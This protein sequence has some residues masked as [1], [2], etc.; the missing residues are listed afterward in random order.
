[1]SNPNI[2][3]VEDNY[4][5][6]SEIQNYL[7]NCS[8]NI[9][10]HAI[11]GMDAIEMTRSKNPDVVIM[12]IGL[13]GE[14]S[15]IEAAG[16]IQKNSETPII[17]LTE[18][19]S[20]Y[21]YREVKKNVKSEFVSKPFKSIHLLNALDNVFLR[22]W[23]YVPN[24][25][26]TLYAR[27]KQGNPHAFVCFQASDILFIRGHGSNSTVFTYE[28]TYAITSSLQQIEIRLSKIDYFVRVNRF[29]IVNASIVHLVEGKSN[30]KSFKVDRKDKQTEH[31]TISAKYQKQV[32]EKIFRL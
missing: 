13:E 10:G 17:F 6:A 25:N 27:L 11:S 18:E 5:H 29:E 24:L 4:F 22:Y 7:E 16:E 31:I 9:V 26:T 3:I 19:E 14:M 23:E 15:G 30:V 21:R 28:A 20:Q 12:D 2:L 32:L 1:M 8:Y